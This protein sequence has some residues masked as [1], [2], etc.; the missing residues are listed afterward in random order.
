MD[1]MG[2][3]TSHLLRFRASETMVLP[4]VHTWPNLDQRLEFGRKDRNVSSIAATMLSSSMIFVSDL[5]QCRQIRHV[6]YIMCN[7]CCK[8]M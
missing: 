8:S 2:Y 7:V 3:V 4:G 6:E 1:P 5:M